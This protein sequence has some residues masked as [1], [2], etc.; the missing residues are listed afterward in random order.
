MDLKK[1][2]K[3]KYFESLEKKYSNNFIGILEKH[4]FEGNTNRQ[5]KTLVISYMLKTIKS[6][7]EVYTNMELPMH[8]KVYYPQ[9]PTEHPNVI[10][11]DA[12]YP[13]G[14]FKAL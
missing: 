5:E 6:L 7:E 1:D 2:I 12:E 11:K 13:I 9:N 4:I 8:G 10:V 14:Q 3:N